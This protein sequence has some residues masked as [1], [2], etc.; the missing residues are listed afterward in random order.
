[1]DICDYGYSDLWVPMRLW[2]LCA[3]ITNEVYVTDRRGTHPDDEVVG[4]S[5]PVGHWHLNPVTRR[6][7]G[8][9]PGG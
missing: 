1:M 7:K 4:A 8:R 6:Y 2:V 9:D 3:T 5:V